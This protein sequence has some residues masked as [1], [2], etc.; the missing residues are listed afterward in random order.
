MFCLAVGAA[1][2][3][4]A[5]AGTCT[6]TAVAQYCTPR[7][8]HHT[9]PAAG[10]QD[11]DPPGEQPACRREDRAPCGHEKTRAQ[12][13]RWHGWRITQRILSRNDSCA[14][15]TDADGAAAGS[16]VRP[17]SASAGAAS[18]SADSAATVSSCP[19]RMWASG[20]TMAAAGKKKEKGMRDSKEIVTATAC[21]VRAAPSKPRQKYRVGPT[22]SGP[23][24]V[25]RRTERACVRAGAAPAICCWRRTVTGERSGV[26]A[27]GSSLPCRAPGRRRVANNSPTSPSPRTRT[28]VARVVP[29]GFCLAGGRRLNCGLRRQPLTRL[30]HCVPG[31]ESTHCHP[32]PWFPEFRIMW[33]ESPDHQRKPANHSLLSLFFFSES[34]QLYLQM[35]NLCKHVSTVRVAD[36]VRSLTARPY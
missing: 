16:P 28:Q 6:C 2:G 15:A 17:A 22:T 20:V 5:A 36:N 4:R 21:G 30:C 19:H 10:A 31:R 7:T 9:H 32:C 35:V 34:F 24:P 29:A 3:W 25:S 33:C 1:P 23:V 13:A 27:S 8:A 11:P 26:E 12:A 14:A 18:S